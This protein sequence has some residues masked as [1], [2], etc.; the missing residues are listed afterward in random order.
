VLFYKII[1]I[2]ITYKKERFSYM[3]F[4]LNEHAE[5]ALGLYKEVLSFFHVIFLILSWWQTLC[6]QNHMEM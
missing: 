6:T 4:V 2:E 3:C 5:S 1:G